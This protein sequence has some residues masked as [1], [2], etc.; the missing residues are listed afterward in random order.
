MVKIKGTVNGVPCV[1][2]SGA[3]TVPLDDMTE[4]GG[5]IVAFVSKWLTEN[6]NRID[7]DVSSGSSPTLDGTNVTGMPTA[8]LVDS[9]G[10]V[11]L[12]ASQTSQTL[13]F[14]TA[15][16]FDAT[17]GLAAT[18]TLTGNTTPALISNAVA[19][20]IAF[21]TAIQD[22]NAGRFIDWS[23]FV[24]VDIDNIAMSAGSKTTYMIYVES[25]TIQR[26]TVLS[27]DTRTAKRLIEYPGSGFVNISSGAPEIWD[28]VEVSSVWTWPEVRRYEYALYTDLQKSGPI[29]SQA[30]KDKLVGMKSRAP[31]TKILANIRWDLW[32]F[33]DAGGILFPDRQWG[34]A[35]IAGGV[36]PT[37]AMGE[38][39]DDAN[40]WATAQ[41]AIEAA[42]YTQATENATIS[43]NGALLSNPYNIALDF[44]GTGDWWVQM[45]Q[46]D[47]ADTDWHELLAEFEADQRKLEP[48]VD[49]Y[50]LHP[51]KPQKYT[52][53]TDAIDQLSE[54]IE[55]TG[56][57]NPGWVLATN[58][59][60]SVE[61]S[62]VNNAELY[63]ERDGTTTILDLFEGFENFVDR[64]KF[65][66]PR[67]FILIGFESSTVDTWRNVVKKAAF[68][69]AY[70]AKYGGTNA[71][72]D[73]HWAD[74]ISRVAAKGD[75][76]EFPPDDH[77]ED[78]SV[79]WA[80][81]IRAHPGW[82]VTPPVPQDI[83]LLAQMGGKT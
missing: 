41:I 73:Q 60:G 75:A 43:D 59:G 2:D 7:Q 36:K 78:F 26:V 40:T 28:N 15:L 61:A 50:Y 67:A 35:G 8:G 37:L 31:N 56:T 24:G 82:V 25:P 81:Q 6:V 71:D 21:L 5:D 76:V 66:D 42:G 65:W 49:G 18:V 51:N 22:A 17:L 74:I 63:D 13:T 45:N 30:L 46:M 44:A 34:A 47:V 62:W 20:D 33:W 68:R 80:N 10:I 48:T 70:I 11:R 12:L 38:V 55:N 9:A 14:T 72:A 4:D 27:S 3:P 19:G 1:V 64:V 58:S 69:V 53:P 16:A 23:N 39:V 52:N 77:A 79:D 32:W 54:W 83:S 57:V 29:Y